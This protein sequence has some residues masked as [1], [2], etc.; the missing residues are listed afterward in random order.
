ME[1]A[2]QAK[3]RKTSKNSDSMGRTD[4]NQCEHI[5][6]FSDPEMMKEIFQNNFLNNKNK[7]I[8]NKEENVSIDDLKIQNCKIPKP[9]YESNSK[10]N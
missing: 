2:K 6:D 9:K 7:Q 8:Q 3:Q 5:N 10:I 1:S 4:E